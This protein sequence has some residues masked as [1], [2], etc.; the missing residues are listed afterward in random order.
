MIPINK[1]QELDGPLKGQKASVIMANAAKI[2]A[3]VKNR[4]VFIYEKNACIARRIEVNS[5]R[6]VAVP[7]MSHC[8]GSTT[9]DDLSDSEIARFVKAGGM[10]IQ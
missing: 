4:N 3:L 10:I 1:M 8:N 9:G 6:I 2:E 7:L 5:G